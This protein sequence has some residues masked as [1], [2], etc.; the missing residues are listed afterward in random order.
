MGEEKSTGGLA[1]TLPFRSFLSDSQRSRRLFYFSLT[2]EDAEGTEIKRI[3]RWI[4]I[5]PTF[6]SRDSLTEEK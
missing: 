4:E 6:L 2:A 3:N 5:H 1:T